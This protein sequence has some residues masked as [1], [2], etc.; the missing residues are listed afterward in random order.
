VRNYRSRNDS[1]TVIPPL[2]TTA[3][4]TIYEIWNTGAHCTIYRQ[5]N[6]LKMVSFRQLVWLDPPPDSF[7]L[8]AALTVYI[9]LVSPS[10]SAQFQGLS[11]D[12]FISSV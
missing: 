8:S 3:P 6:R 5:L 9:C 11:I 4:V 1:K 2:S 10:E 7:F 12:L